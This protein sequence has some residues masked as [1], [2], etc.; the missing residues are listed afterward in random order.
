MG[1][2]KRNEKE[3]TVKKEKEQREEGEVYRRAGEAARWRDMIGS[4]PGSSLHNDPGLCVTYD[5]SRR[6]VFVVS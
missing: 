5:L 4:N 1:N 2:G 6:P 3:E